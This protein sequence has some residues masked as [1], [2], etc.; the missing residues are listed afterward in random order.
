[1][2]A[3]RGRFSWIDGDELREMEMEEGDSYAIESG[4]VFHYENMDEGQRFQV[5]SIHD[6]LLLKKNRN[7]KTPSS[8]AAP[9]DAHSHSQEEEEEDD[10]DNDLQAHQTSFH[11]RIWSLLS[12]IIMLLLVPTVS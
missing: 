3:G 8:Y 7:R 11:V 5:F 10:E 4:T 1:M 9:H 12:L 2:R 6:L